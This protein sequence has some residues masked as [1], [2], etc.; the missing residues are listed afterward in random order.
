MYKLCS[1]LD[2]VFVLSINISVCGKGIVCVLKR[3][4]EN[5]S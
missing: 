1:N 3:V 4:K 2:I 5:Q